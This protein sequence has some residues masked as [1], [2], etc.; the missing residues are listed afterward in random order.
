MP[1]RNKKEI[2]LP[3]SYCSKLS[4]ERKK[5]ETVISLVFLKGEEIVHKK[6]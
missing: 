3:Y 5:K 4:S 1:G 6:P 2:Y